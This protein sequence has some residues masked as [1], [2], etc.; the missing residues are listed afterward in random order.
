MNVVIVGGG[1]AG[2]GAAHKVR[3]AAE[4]GHDVSFELYEKDPRLGG[5]IQSEEVDGFVVDGGPDCFLTMKPAVHRVARLTGISDD[6]LP[7]DEARKRTYILARGGL[8]D[9]PDGVMM[10]VPTKFMPFVTTG[11]FSWPGKFRMGMDLV[12]PRKKEAGDETLESFVLRRLG[13][14]CLDNLA[15]PLVGGVHAS[16]PALMSLAATF[17]RLLEMEQKSRSMVVASVAARRKAAQM[18]KAHPPKPGA[19]P[20]TFFTSFAGGMQQLTDA[21]ADAAGREHIHAGVSVERLERTDA[22]WR[23]HLSEGGPVEADAVIVATEGWAAASL[24]APLD[25]GTGDALERI[26]HS[27]SAT[28]SLA[29]DEADIGIDTNAFGLLCPLVAGRKLMAATYSSTKWPGRAPAGKFLIRG[30]VGGPHNQQVM[31]NGDGA[32]AD[33]VL[34]E[35]RDILGIGGEP[36][37]ARVY[38][39]E[40]GMPQYTMGH[41]DRVAAIERWASETPGMGVA[42]GSY[43]GVGVPNCIESGEAAVSKV[44][45]DAGVTLEEDTAPKGPPGRP[46]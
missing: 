5:K 21:L 20:S 8:H 35:V 15:E 23:V 17:P 27:S 6:L 39:W 25:P 19:R 2:L 26:P 32:L 37:W 12:I 9:L 22:G 43:R 45:G 30:F 14:E 38:R 10:M 4:A 3:R 28:I 33:I 42:G 46:G 40:R 44:L 1:V 36:E 41:L 7:S 29:F 13:K 18:K 34:S 16:D 11:L 24:L 31:E